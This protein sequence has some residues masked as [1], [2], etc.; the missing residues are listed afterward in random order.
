MEDMTKEWI[1]ELVHKICREQVALECK[2][3]LNR[4]KDDLNT[5]KEELENRQKEELKNIKN[6]LQTYKN[7]ITSKYESELSTNIQKTKEEYKKEW[8]LYKG[9]VQKN[10]NEFINQ[11]KK[12]I[13]LIKK[14]IENLLPAAAVTGL[15]AAYKEATDE[16]RHIKYSLLFAGFIIPL[17]LLVWGFYEY[18]LIAEDLNFLSLISRLFVGFPLAW[19]AWFFQRSISQTRR[20]REEYNHKQRM[21]TV[22]EGFNNYIKTVETDGDKELEKMFSNQVIKIIGKNP[23]ETLGESTTLLDSLK[24]DLN[25]KS[26]S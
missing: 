14:R 21:M 25:K 6:D 26:S 18:V 15:A 5:Y 22:Y 2:N 16:L 17:I 3:A 4:N 7:Q 13:S 19:I 8:E 1:E 24:E 11:I 10:N 20:L 23:A 9:E 12:S